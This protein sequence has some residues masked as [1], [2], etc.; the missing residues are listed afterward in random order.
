MLTFAEDES[1]Q[2]L[3]AFWTAYVDA[4]RPGVRHVMSHRH[5]SWEAVRAVRR[6]P[7]IDAAPPAPGGGQAVRGV[8]AAG[9][10][11][12]IPAR[13]LGTGV[14]EIPAEAARYLEGRRAQPLR[15]KIRSAEK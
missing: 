1:E 9:A 10:S 6:L 3:A 7:R 14:L 4:G 2:R 12:G 13:L 5:E 11:Y 15:R 8:L